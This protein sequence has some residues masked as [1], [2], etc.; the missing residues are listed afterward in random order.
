[1]TSVIHMTDAE[2]EAQLTEWATEIYHHLLHLN[3]QVMMKEALS[4]R[5]D[6]LAL[7]CFNFQKDFHIESTS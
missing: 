2:A 6:R 4:D 7:Y 1:M 3:A 5:A